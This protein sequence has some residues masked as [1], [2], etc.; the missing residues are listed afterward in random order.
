[1]STEDPGKEYPG[2]LEKKALSFIP[3]DQDDSP[4]C[5]IYA[6]TDAYSKTICEK[7]G[8]VTENFKSKK[9]FDLTTNCNAEC[10]NNF[11]NL[12]S[13]E[14]K[15][16]L[17]RI[18]GRTIIKKIFST[19]SVDLEYVIKFVNFSLNELLLSDIDNLSETIKRQLFNKQK[20]PSFFTKQAKERIISEREL[21]IN[22]LTV[23][24]RE[25]KLS[26]TINYITT[27]NF[28]LEKGILYGNY[29]SETRTIYDIRYLRDLLKRNRSYAILDEGGPILKTLSYAS[30]EELSLSGDISVL[31]GNDQSLIDEYMK[32]YESMSEIPIKKLFASVIKEVKSA[33]EDVI[34][35]YTV[36]GHSMVLQTLFFYNGRWWALLKNSWGTKVGIKG[37][38]VVPIAAILNANIY[39]PEFKLLDQEALLIQLGIDKEELERLAREAE[40]EEGEGL[41]AV[42]EEENA[43]LMD[44]QLAAQQL[45]AQQL[46][47]QQL[48]A[49]QEAQQEAQ[50]AAQQL[51]A[52]Q[53]AA[54]QLAAQQLAAQQEAAQQLAAQQLGNQD[55]LKNKKRGPG[56]ISS[57]INL[58]IPEKKGGNRFSKKIKC[59][60][61]KRNKRQKGNKTV[62]RYRRMRK[63]RSKNN[64]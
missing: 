49:Q 48:A 59:K 56:K 12:Q 51:A 22:A 30:E 5:G 37:Y 35:E 17:L 14:C 31:F 39:L 16:C 64:V 10:G 54:Q 55:A 57:L 3:G 58:G 13:P 61:S 21:L 47:A 29:T 46:A 44:Q 36:N 43:F 11:E 63:T 1:M 23:I 7:M 34:C 40:E 42:A 27:K 9:S 52:Q 45:A 15:N 19:N 41:K 50:L 25:I 26:E 18:Y 53:E 4:I 6:V 2:K 28:V 33:T 60:K 62:K 32:N 8:W 20:L 38:H 24:F